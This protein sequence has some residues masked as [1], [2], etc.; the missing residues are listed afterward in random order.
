MYLLRNR[1]FQHGAASLLH[2]GIVQRM[3][4]QPHRTRNRGSGRACGV[5]AQGFTKGFVLKIVIAMIFALEIRFSHVGNIKSLLTF[6]KHQLIT[7]STLYTYLSHYLAE[8]ALRSWA[9][10]FPSWLIYRS[11]DAHQESGEGGWQAS[12]CKISSW[13][14]RGGK[15]IMKKLRTFKNNS[16]IS[17]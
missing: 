8:L 5:Q 9:T 16:G 4:K 13:R 14:L 2:D 3:W 11:T 17:F 6:W 1:N 10:L 12:H 15:G 7:K